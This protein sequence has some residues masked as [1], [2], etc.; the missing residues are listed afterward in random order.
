MPIF[1]YVCR[2]CHHR[3]EAVVQ[4]SR[5]ASCPKCESRKL[6][7]QISSFGIGGYKGY[8]VSSEGFGRVDTGSSRC[9]TTVARKDN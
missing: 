2:E 7:K 9:R 1:E 8:A 5:K 4:G 6:E 3:F